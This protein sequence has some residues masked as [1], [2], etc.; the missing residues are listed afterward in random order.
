MTEG[1]S[2]C[3]CAP[4]SLPFRP[5]PAP[6]SFLLRKN[7][8]TRVRLYFDYLEINNPWDSQD[9]NQIPSAVKS[10]KADPVRFST[11]P[12]PFS[13]NHADCMQKATPFIYIVILAITATTLSIRSPRP[14]L[15][16]PQPSI[17]KLALP[18]PQVPSTP[19]AVQPSP[20]HPA[21]TE[22]EPAAIS[23]TPPVSPWPQIESDIA[24][25][26]T[27]TF[28]ALANGLRY[29]IYPN[30]EPQKRLSLRLHIASGSLMEADDQQG[31]AHFLE[32][33]VFNGSKNY[34][35]AELI[36]KM[37]RLGISFGAHANAYTSF[38]ETVYMLD[39]PDLS[40]ETLKLGFTVMRDFGDG[41]L[42][43]RE[44]IDKERGVILSEKVSRDSVETRLME[45]QF[46]KILPNSRIA[47]RFPIGLEEVIKSAPRERFVDLYSRYY[48]PSRM[49]LIVVGDIDPK[50]MQVKIE[51]TFSSMVNPQ[52]SGK[53]PDLGTIQQ[54]EGIEPAIF[55]DQEL[56][57]T[58]IS[59]TLVRPYQPEPDSAATRAKH[60]A[61][62]IAHSI[63]NRRFERLAK[64]KGSAI[65]AGSASYNALF[66]NLELGSIDVTAADD[67]WQEAVPILEQEFR[68]AFDYGFSADELAE[69]KSNTLNAY[70]QQVKQQATRKSELI[71]SALAKSIN[72]N[73]VFSDPT[74]DLE[75]AKHALDT[76][77]LATCH[78]ALKKFW[79][80]PGYHLTLTTKDHPAN[81]EKDLA[82]LFEESRGK[83]VTA[84]IQRANQTFGY[85]NFGKPGKTI[86]RTEVKDLGIT[87]LVLSNRVRVNLKPTDFEQGKICLSARIGSGKLTQPKDMPMLDIFATALFEGGGLGK[88]T[89][90]QLQQ[91][92]AGKNVGTSLSIGE[93]TF[94][95]S[96]TTTPAD[97]GTELQLMS[98]TLTDP[99]YREE[100]LWQF[101]K[102]IPML[103]Q[104][105]KH[106][107]AGP[108]QEMQ[109]WLHGGDSRFTA[110]PVEKLSAYTIDDVKKW[111]TPELTKGYLELT[112]VGD[113]EISQILP[114]LLATFGAI[115]TRA[116][117][118]PALLPARK[119]QLPKAP[120]A[121]TFTYDSKV[122]QAI[123]TTL[124]KTVGL[125]DNTTE[126]RRL[127]ILGEIYGDR[128]REEIREKLGASYSP[129]AGADG[130]NAFEGVGYLIG[131]SVGKPEDLERLLNT[132]REL[133]NQ[134]ALHGATADELE[135]ALKPTLGQLEKS[136]RDNNYWLTTVM[137]ECQSNPKR[138]E[139]ARNREADYR[140][141]T[142]TEINDL[143]K[144]YFTAENALLV[145][146]KPA[147]LER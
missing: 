100:A 142:L 39:L 29:I 16:Q 124:W 76:L 144:K 30:R 66:N 81:A 68:R 115:P 35:A 95:L 87:Q 77:D 13:L 133:A 40:P 127:N 110:A 101:R 106:T 26:H 80:A 46:L 131:Q 135:R 31:L 49:T 79:E 123:A 22:T 17:P 58:E 91:I 61:L 140:S 139:F 134:L 137:S 97:L 86:L 126:F 28:G 8:T 116:L 21:A 147:A 82:A 4:L 108:Q 63:I 129:N 73:R 83:S 88:H 93:D 122:P 18:P 121:K 105:L 48:T 52:N 98:A 128:L 109:A 94:I 70:E 146:I 20:P 85:T 118:A 111:L 78:L 45:Q 14:R 130:S 36:P 10:S 117:V 33:M 2:L 112:L 69:A 99:G 56:T 11:L 37:Q 59:L 113:F 57:S 90:D 54:P 132:M 143:A 42:L 1:L 102:A 24:P 75:L 120:A 55:A 60:L 62:D 64:I 103:Y 84:P 136:L 32:H 27:A 71:A 47:R 72:D 7:P 65:A 107:A 50:A 43:T 92:F 12:N 3:H 125:R 74:T 67:R 145:G 41:A 114:E 96:G 53:N 89:N 51:T 6:L 19:A 138:L 44:E 9:P 23:V 15:S 104:Q 119:I 25:D 34:S 141:I 38:D 5:V